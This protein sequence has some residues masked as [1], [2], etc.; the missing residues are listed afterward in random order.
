MSADLL[1][2]FC[3]RPKA[4]GQ[5]HRVIPIREETS[6]PRESV[7]TDLDSLSGPILPDRRGR[8]SLLLTGLRIRSLS[9][10][11][12]LSYDLPPLFPTPLEVLV[13]RAGNH[14][15][16]LSE[17]PV[18][19]RPGIVQYLLGP[20]TPGRCPAGGC[21]RLGPA[22]CPYGHERGGP[23]HG[24]LGAPPAP[25]CCWPFEGPR[26]VKAPGAGGGGFK[27]IGMPRWR[28]QE[29]QPTPPSWS[30]LGPCGPGR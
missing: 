26:R 3:T 17:S 13:P 25:P 21:V 15:I 10:L 4:F 14:G 7:V 12:S 11:G 27:F 5:L 9:D 30:S 18:P 6:T 29:P 19:A 8:F 2:R 24:P 28:P 1:R 22:R 20:P 16:R 23:R